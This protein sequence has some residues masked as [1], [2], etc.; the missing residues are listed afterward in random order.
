MQLKINMEN[1][2]NLKI[3]LIVLIA[4]LTSV[5]CLVDDE[6]KTLDAV[7]NTPYVVGFKTKAASESYFQDLGAIPASYKV[8]LIGGQDGTP[9]DTDLV[10]TYQV[11][12]ESTATAGVEFD[13]VNTPG[14]VTIPANS[15]FATIDILINTGNFNLTSPTTLIL[16]LVSVQNDG[17]LIAAQ[18]NQL[19][20][21]FVGCQADAHL[22]D[23]Q[24]TTVQLSNGNLVNNQVE[25]IALTSVNNFRTRTVGSF[26][27]G[28]ASG[29]L[30]P[31]ANYDGYNFS[32]ICGEITV[33][34]QN[35]GGYYS[36]LVF[37]SGSI[38]QDTGT[39]T[40]TYTV[41]FGSGDR[42]YTSTYTR[43]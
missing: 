30:V 17:A 12:S 28:A 9:A 2:K 20:V 16:D 27:V 7:A 10:L 36:N 31:P 23:Y 34:E 8:D 11:S 3:L 37:G 21:T 43:L 19:V 4:S 42:A 22:Y 38:D 6:D 33:P 35:L 41:T 1:M 18:N 40:V 32:V 15:D 26:G 24:V 13:F 5:S 29:S 25:N 14:T 39:I